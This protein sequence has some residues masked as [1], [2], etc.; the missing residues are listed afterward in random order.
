MDLES[1]F[2]QA[3]EE[4]V[5]HCKKPEYDS[6]FQS[7]SDCDAYRS[8]VAMGSDALPLIRKLFDKPEDDQPE[9]KLEFS[10]IKRHGLVRAVRDIVGPEF[11]IPDEIKGKIQVIEGRIQATGKT[12]LPEDYTKRWLDE[13]MSKY[14][15]K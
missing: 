6:S 11:T 13:H 9:D 1:R 10:R 5:V 14:V 8:I 15:P 4:W 2:N 7:L 3:V 12:S